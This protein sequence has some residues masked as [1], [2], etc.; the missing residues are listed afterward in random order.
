MIFV[1][2]STILRW[3]DVSA[4]AIFILSIIFSCLFLKL[5]NT[6]SNEVSKSNYDITI[7]YDRLISGTASGNLNQHIVSKDESYLNGIGCVKNGF[8]YTYTY[9][10]NKSYLCKAPIA[11]VSDKYP[12]LEGFELSYINVVDSAIFFIGRPSGSVE[13]FAIYS[14]GIEGGNLHKIPIDINNSITSLASNSNYLYFTV[15]YEPYIYSSTIDGSNV[16]T[17]LSFPSGCTG[18][19]LFGVDKTNLYYVSDNGAG[20]IDVSNAKNNILAP[21]CT[22]IIQEPILTDFG[23][24][25]FNDLSKSEYVN[26]SEDGSSTSRIFNSKELTSS[27]IDNI[28]YSSD[29]LFVQIDDGIY[30]SKIGTSSFEKL[31]GVVVDHNTN[32]FMNNEYCIYQKDGKWLSIN[33]NWLLSQ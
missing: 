23:I 29:Y 26:V 10:N 5:P 28:N 31:K 4:I 30:Y 20:K 12:I 9:E 16:E 7:S 17:L 32:F 22:S 13:K 19:H 6:I 3:L 14:I 27:Q 33:I 21:D 25:Y 1:K 8:F 11:N 15:D 2:E 18:I 24:F